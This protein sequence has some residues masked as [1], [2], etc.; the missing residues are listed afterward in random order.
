[1]KKNDKILHLFT[2]IF[3]YIE[4]YVNLSLSDNDKRQ[5]TPNNSIGIEKELEIQQETYEILIRKLE[6]DLRNQ[7]KVNKNLIKIYEK[8]L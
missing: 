7:L 5:K 1:L 8:I 2:T 6:S 3:E 4:N